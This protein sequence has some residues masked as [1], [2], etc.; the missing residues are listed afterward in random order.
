MFDFDGCSSRL[1]DLPK[2]RKSDLSVP[3]DGWFIAECRSSFPR[4]KLSVLLVKSRRGQEAEE[5]TGHDE[6]RS[7]ERSAGAECEV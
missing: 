3:Q 6:K 5:K 4:M 7:M 2:S 1:C